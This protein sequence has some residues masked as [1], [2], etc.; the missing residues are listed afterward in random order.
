[1]KNKTDVNVADLKEKLGELL[2]QIETH[3]SAAHAQS[4]QTILTLQAQ[5]RAAEQQARLFGALA[6]AFEPPEASTVPVEHEDLA[7]WEDDDGE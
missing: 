1:V 3:A 5:E 7:G 6:V 4:I 2:S